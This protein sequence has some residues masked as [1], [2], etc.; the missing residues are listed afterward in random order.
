M[1]ANLLPLHPYSSKSQSFFP[2]L[3]VH[4]ASNIK[5]DLADPAPNTNNCKY[6]WENSCRSHFGNLI[7]LWG[8]HAANK[9][10]HKLSTNR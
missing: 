10:E 2:F 3:D 9:E 8:D 6:K 4:V 7:A 1:I 5:C